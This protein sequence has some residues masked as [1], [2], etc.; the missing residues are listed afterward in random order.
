[1]HGA[2]CAAY[3]LM[4]LT[5]LHLQHSCTYSCLHAYHVSLHPVLILMVLILMV[6]VECYQPKKGMV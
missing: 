4:V 2:A 6:L 3:I 1:M 5:I